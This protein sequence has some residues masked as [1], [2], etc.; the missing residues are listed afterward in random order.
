M[1]AFLS[2]DIRVYA[3]FRVRAESVLTIGGFRNLPYRFPGPFAFPPGAPSPKPDPGGAAT[4]VVHLDPTHP[5]SD[6]PKGL[7]AE[8][9]I[10][11]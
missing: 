4:D 11:N 1:G 10:A 3:V 8:T 9:R 7:S 2:A 6:F 5:V